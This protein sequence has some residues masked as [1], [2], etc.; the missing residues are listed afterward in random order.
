MNWLAH[1]YLAEDTPHAWIGNL[2]GDFA[3]GLDPETLHPLVR[4]GLDHHRAVD[5]FTDAHPLHRASRARYAKH[6]RHFAGVLV[7]LTYDHFLARAWERWSSEPL[8]HFAAR[9]HRVLADHEPLLSPELREAAPHLQRQQWLLSYRDDAG[10]ERVLRGIESR[11]RHRMELVPA[12]E[13]LSAER[14]A[15]QAEFDAFFPA[16]VIAQKRCQAP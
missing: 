4:S 13:I 3:R 9:V 1:L 8:E 6:F 15:L 16:L 7:D 14:A 12:L 5:R 2:V 11:T 10:L